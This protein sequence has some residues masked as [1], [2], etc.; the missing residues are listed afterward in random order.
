MICPHCNSGLYLE[1]C[2]RDDLPL[3]NFHCPACG[4]KL[5][6]VMGVPVPGHTPGGVLVVFPT[7][8]TAIEW[9]LEQIQRVPSLK[10]LAL[11]YVVQFKALCDPIIR[12]G[13]ALEEKRKYIQQR[14]DLLAAKLHRLLDEV[15]QK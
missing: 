13:L 5:H 14:R 9:L 4:H 6:I 8:D 1:G 2:P 10:P 11:E 3:L 15:T 12:S 7:S